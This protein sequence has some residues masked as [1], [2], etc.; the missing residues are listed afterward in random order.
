MTR[1]PSPP[2]ARSHRVA[3][4]DR[5]SSR[6][7][8][9]AWAWAFVLGAALAIVGFAPAQWLAK[10]LAQATGGK[11]QLV[12]AQG[13]VWTGHADVFMTGGAG[14][15]DRTALP[16][17]VHWQLHPAWLGLAVT[18][19]AP[20][21]TPQGLSLR[22]HPGWNSLKLELPAHDSQWP[23]DLLTGL[24]TPWNTLQLQ[25]QLVL[26]TPGLTL[27][28]GPGGLRSSGNATLNILNAASRL[29][30]VRPMGSYR[31]EWLS[32]GEGGRD[33]KLTLATLEG[34][35]QL[36]GQG[37]WVAGRLRF[38]GDAQA[39]PGREEALT[40]LLNILGRRQGALTLIKIG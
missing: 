27:H 5:G 6:K 23:A 33:A 2:P 16:G 32:S 35:L 21:C 34:A 31:L 9:V 37:Q 10:P 17:G 25:G 38:E 24:G 13:T 20:C 30:T 22:L 1:K 18:L 19:N 11:V 26:Q 40:N 3:A 29:S 28:M 14:S 4:T 39:S 15:Q 36:Q 8:A 7:S 12:N